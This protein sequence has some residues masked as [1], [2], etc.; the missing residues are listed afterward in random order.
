MTFKDISTFNHEI[1][2]IQGIALALNNNAT[3]P[4]L[5]AAKVL[6]EIAYKLMQEVAG[7]D[8]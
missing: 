2:V 3:A 5:D 8:T 4:L 7:N 6:E 1:G